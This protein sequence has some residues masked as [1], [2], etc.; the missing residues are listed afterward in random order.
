MLANGTPT[1]LYVPP[2]RRSCASSKFAAIQG[3]CTGPPSLAPFGV[4]PVFK[5]GTSSYDPDLDDAEGRIVEQHYNCSE[6]GV[7]G[8]GN[9]GRHAAPGT[10]SHTSM[11]ERAAR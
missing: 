4:D 11:L 1:Y 3:S 2:A 8:D 10:R 5:R 9:D 7:A 6:V